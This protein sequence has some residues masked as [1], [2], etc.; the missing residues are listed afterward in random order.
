MKFLWEVVCHQ[1]GDLG[2]RLVSATNTAFVES[3]SG[4]V[5]CPDGFCLVDIR[6]CQQPARAMVAQI[7][8]C[9]EEL[10]QSPCYPAQASA[11]LKELMKCKL[12]EQGITHLERNGKIFTETF[13]SAEQTLLVLSDQVLS[14][15]GGSECIPQPCKEL[16]NSA[17]QNLCKRVYLHGSCS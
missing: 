11:L 15:T 17:P 2:A 16:N 7:Y 8:K 10:F 13:S 12:P 4:Q 14:V 9:H 3:L 1:H 6:A 5:F